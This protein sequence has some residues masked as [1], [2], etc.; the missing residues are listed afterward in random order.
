MITP[1]R[2][3]LA[4]AGVAVAGCWLFAAPPSQHPGG[5]A[6]PS[7]SSGGKTP[8]AA[9]P[10][11]A[12]N[13]YCYVCHTIFDGEKLTAVHQRVGVG[14][15][16]C[17]G[18]SVKHS[19]D[20]DGLTPPEKMYAKSQVNSFCTSCHGKSK[21]L[22]RE[23]HQ[24]FFNQMQPGE[25]CSDCHA[26]KHHL[27]VRTRIWDKTTG[28]LLKDDGVRMMQKDSPATEGAAQKAK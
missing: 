15:E 5:D 23:D 11:P 1:C 25:T 7:A 13:S 19:G 18:T 16:Q 8:P 3:F 27:K 2:A 26:A 12:D 14:C 21:L 6:Q 10:E 22:K 17:H 28:K 9:Q 4:L 20:E 24:E